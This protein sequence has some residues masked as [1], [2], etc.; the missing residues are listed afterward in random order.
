MRVNRREFI[1]CG[2]I[3]M[4]GLVLGGGLSAKH[5][6]AA[7]YRYQVSDDC[8]GCQRCYA[9]CPNNAINISEVPVRIMQENCWRCGNCYEACP[10]EAI[11]REAVS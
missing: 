10:A 7:G 3:C 5:V 8:T 11:R 1:K 9:V 4:M 2:G 6:E